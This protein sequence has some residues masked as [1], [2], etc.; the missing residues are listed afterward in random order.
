VRRVR[1]QVMKGPERM[2]GG[3]CALGRGSRAILSEIV[4]MQR[5]ISRV[6]FE[7]QAG[8]DQAGLRSERLERSSWCMVMIV[9]RRYFVEFRESRALTRRSSPLYIPD[10]DHIRSRWFVR[11]RLGLH[12]YSLRRDRGLIEGGANRG[13]W[14]ML[15]HTLDN[16]EA[17]EGD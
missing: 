7:L 1:S 9:V 11:V 14:I 4:D 8:G 15:Q 5:V 16:F 13:R 2:G 3:E 6:S 12:D 10:G 17:R